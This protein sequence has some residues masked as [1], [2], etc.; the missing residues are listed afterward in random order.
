MLIQRLTPSQD[1]IKYPNFEQSED[2]LLSTMAVK[3]PSTTTSKLSPSERLARKRAAARLRQQRCRA[4]KRQAMLQRR[5]EN[6]VRQGQISP[7]SSPRSVMESPQTSPPVFSNSR[8]KVVE[9]WGRTRTPSEPIYHCVSF[10]SQ[11]S[12]E[13][14]Q[15]S[16]ERL[17]AVSHAR[18]Q[19]P[20][21]S[22]PSIP[23]KKRPA[24][25]I[26]SVSDSDESLVPEEEA[27]VAA[28][29]SLKKVSTVQ[30]PKSKPSPEPSKPCEVRSL[31]SGSRSPHSTKYR[32]YRSWQPR[33][34]E[35]FKHGRPPRVPEFY[36]MPSQRPSLPQYRY[37]PTYPRYSRYE[38]D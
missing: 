8:V 1:T 3:T 11:R 13:D 22:P 5:Q 2:K 16:N 27:A 28:M 38:Y 12:F 34:Y 21:R 7:H 36:K 25:A 30:A 33:H 37:Y 35:T 14:A 4:R 18:D 31:P 10:E 29:L 26:S 9:C 24:D 15:K 19:T 32:Y 17:S 23:L 20:P 6:K